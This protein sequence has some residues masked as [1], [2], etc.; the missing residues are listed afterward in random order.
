MSE[1]IHRVRRQSAP[2][3]DVT[4]IPPRAVRPPLAGVGRRCVAAVIDMVFLFALGFALGR[5]FDQE[6]IAEAGQISFSLSG[7]PAA[8]WLAA[9]FVYPI[10]TESAIGA[11]LGKLLVGLRVVTE[12]GRPV[13]LGASVV[14]NLLRIVDFLPF[15]YIAGLAFMAGSDLRQRFGDRAAHTLVI[16]RA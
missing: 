6:A 8:I 7:L 15:F 14:R 9:L 11:T 4:P 1:S 13:G 16:T 5:L 3:P 10:V 2:A 12:D